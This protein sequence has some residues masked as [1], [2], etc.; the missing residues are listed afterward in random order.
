MAYHHFNILLLHSNTK[1]SNCLLVQVERMTTCSND[2]TLYLKI[3]RFNWLIH[4]YNLKYDTLLMKI[5]IFPCQ[6]HNVKCPY[7]AL[8]ATITLV[9]CFINEKTLY[10]HLNKPSLF[11]WRLAC[12]RKTM[13]WHSGTDTL[14]VNYCIAFLL[15]QIVRDNI[16]YWRF[17]VTKL[18]FYH[19][20]VS[21]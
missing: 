8:P 16:C 3:S 7:G 10:M 14:C 9:D 19:C 5:L 18:N 13:C 17:Y 4:I 15:A 11:D 1:F 20:L 2:R 6:W 12:S 21:L